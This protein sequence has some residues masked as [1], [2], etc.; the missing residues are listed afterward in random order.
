MKKPALLA[1]AMNTGMW[2]AA[3]TQRNLA[4]LRAD[5]YHVVGPNSGNLACGD[6]GAGRM[7]EPDEI[8]EAALALLG[9]N[10]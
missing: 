6:V 7:A 5:G 4:A 1:P 8:I 9:N 2:T 3:P 10:A